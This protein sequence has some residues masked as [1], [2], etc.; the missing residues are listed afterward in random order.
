MT[1]TINRLTNLFLLVL[2][3]LSIVALIA[4][5]FQLRVD[6]FL[7]IWILG[8]C[9]CLW[10]ASSFRRGFWIG[11]PL[12]ALL[13]YGAYLYYHADLIR[14]LFDIFDHVSVVF[15]THVYHPGA[16]H[17]FSEAAESHSLVVLL[18]TF[19]L[20][21]YLVAALCAKF[22]RA[23]LSL[24]ATIPLF[25]VCIIVNGETAPLPTIGLILFWCLLFLS[26]G[27]YQQDGSGGRTALLCL[28]PLCLLLGGLLLFYN[29]E[30]YVRDD[31]ELLLYERFQKLS[32]YFDLFYGHRSTEDLDPNASGN[33]SEKES[34]RS[35]FRSFWET[36]DDQMKL[37][38]DYDYEHADL[39]VMEVYVERSGRLYLR[40]RSF[41][42]YT[43]AGWTAAEELSSGSSLPFTA[44]AAMS[45]PESTQREAEIHTYMDLDTLCLP[46]FSAVSS[47]SDVFVSSEQ[48]ESY[49]ITY[50][51][52][53]GDP[54][55]LR[56]PDN[57]ESAERSY[58]S[59]AHS[60]YTDLPI[61]TR[62]A[63]LRLLEDAGI[64]ANDPA[65]IDRIAD[66]VCQ[67][68]EYDLDTPPFPSDDYAIYFLTEAHRGF[69][70]HY[71]TAAA[72]L[73]RSMG[74]P[75]RVTDGFLIDAQ[76]RRMNDVLGQNAH[77]WV[78]VYLD[79]VGWIPVEVTQRVGGAS[80]EPEPSPSD[81]PEP[82]PS[83]GPDSPPN[84]PDASPEGSDEPQGSA[85]EEPT[86]P[87]PDVTEEPVVEESPSPEEPQPDEIEKRGHFPW[88]I[89]LIPL[90][91]LM[92]LPLWYAF[93]RLLF[94]QRIH[95][96]D[97]GK[98]AVAIFAYAQQ[99]SAYGTETPELILQ[100][101]EKAV[102]S[103]H[104]IERDE[105]R[106]SEKAL[107][108]MLDTI[109]PKLNPAQKFR[110]RFLQGLR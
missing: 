52:Y 9:V 90:C 109:Y 40:S 84:E 92:L 28:I 48:Q 106:V 43:G 110:F 93:R 45:S 65:L 23:S 56:L 19:P 101:A 66:Y 31:R 44:F 5:N 32:E 49:R 102:F 17:A 97:T 25:A 26:G 50:I 11:M 20:S 35:R 86:A 18:L 3:M 41:G 61:E 95:H 51:D 71:A 70:I 8:T 72:V 68:A 55:A 69:C 76:G 24:L 7:Y 98:A 60:Y 75:A 81:E 22:G 57:A 47:G 46:Y 38:V 100:C 91:L 77:A 87:S 13:L 88:R 12:A 4:D 10:I 80:A 105:L 1:R 94:V 29:P 16:T 39:K 79:G 62:R 89:L 99:A 14:E 27:S 15:Y 78:E 33:E 74:I 6:V 96:P 53:S 54:A 42:S 107:L 36:D 103:N 82:S 104:S 73:Y 2:C 67:S 64:S 37:S 63:A 85:T 21:A 34:E 83:E 30:N 108:Q 58:R 59:Y